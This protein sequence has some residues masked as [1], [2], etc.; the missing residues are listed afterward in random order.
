M[1]IGLRLAG[2]GT[3]LLVG[4][5]SSTATVFASTATTA[6]PSAITATWNHSGGHDGGDHHSGGDHRGG[7][8]HHGDSDHHSDGDH[9]GDGGGC[10]RDRDR[11]W[12][13]SC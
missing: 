1:K 12:W 10:N 9:H 2:L 3:A 11:D 5:L 4:T 6:A 7:G 13:W 8:D